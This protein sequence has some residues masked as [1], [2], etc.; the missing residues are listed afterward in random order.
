MPDIIKE[1]NHNLIDLNN[2]KSE[3]L[4]HNLTSY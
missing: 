3:L 4:D 1:R 2:Q